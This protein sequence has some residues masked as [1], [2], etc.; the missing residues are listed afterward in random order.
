MSARFARSLA[1]A[2]FV[3][4][5][6]ASLVPK[7]TAAATEVT[8]AET[9]STL[10]YPLFRV[11][12]IAYA[13]ANPGV[14]MTTKATGSG[15]GI[16]QAISGEV[17]IGASDAYM[18]DEQV[19]ANPNIINIPLAISAQTVNYNLPGLN[20]THVKLSGPVLA[21]IYAGKI[22]D[23]DAKAISDLNPGVSLP[24][25]A[26]VTVHRLD[27]S[28][29]T[30]MFTQFL[31]FSNE[32]WSDG[33]NYGTSIS[34]PSI[35][36]AVEGVGNPGVIAQIQAHP[37]AIGYVGVSYAGELARDR[38]GTALLQNQDG[39]FLLPTPETI[40]AG[41]DALDPR[42]PPD[43]RLTL[44]YA[45]G[46]NSYPI[47][48]Y[49]YAVVSVKQ[50]DP[51]TAAALRAFLLWAIDTSSGSTPQYLEAAHF[52]ALPVFVRALSIVQIE[53]IQ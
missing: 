35:P 6:A 17:Q 18:S 49:E 2:L 16:A 10:F 37:Y 21:D 51:A 40:R 8:L 19:R 39:T 20:G 46:K 3:A 9:G 38:L 23:W 48:S 47:V 44:V 29:D 1:A 50:R 5:L 28:G 26:I 30:F 33:P 42:T 32:S 12:T 27:S 25:H 43:E 7:G 11:W 45:P 53:K 41:A 13:R 34:W 24:H 36:G 4:A 31:T 22:V 15:A 14:H 52:I